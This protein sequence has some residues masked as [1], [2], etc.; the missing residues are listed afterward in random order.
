MKGLAGHG[1]GPGRSRRQNGDDKQGKEQ[2]EK[3]DAF[4]KQHS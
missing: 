2:A 4:H 1:F 3:H